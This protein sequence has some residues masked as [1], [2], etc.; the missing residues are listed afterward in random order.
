MAIQEN[1]PVGATLP[2][3]GLSRWEQIKVFIPM[4]RESV[5]QRELA[6]RFP[7]RQHLTK[8]CAVWSNREIHKWIADPQNYR[9]EG[10]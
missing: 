6:G 9:A 5:R 8:R 2:V 1:A 7:K 4:S 10:A 3:D